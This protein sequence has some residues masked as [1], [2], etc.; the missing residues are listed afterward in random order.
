[1]Y[2]GFVPDSVNLQERF[3][4]FTDNPFRFRK[5]VEL[6]EKFKVK[7]IMPVVEYDTGSKCMAA[8]EHVIENSGINMTD[9]FV[10]VALCELVSVYGKSNSESMIV[11]PEVEYEFFQEVAFSPVEI[12][13]L[14]HDLYR[15]CSDYS[16]KYLYSYIKETSDSLVLFELI[17][18]LRE[19]HSIV[20]KKFGVGSSYKSITDIFYIWDEP[21]LCEQF[22][23]VEILRCNP[24][25][26]IRES[27]SFLK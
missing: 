2:Y 8:M 25:Y 15:L 5:Y 21:A 10:E 17:K 11:V 16:I 7:N 23:A 9:N 20:S 27:K 14:S 6:M 3:S 1:M 13:K 24:F 4:G 26:S 22:I 12:R 18:R 19:I